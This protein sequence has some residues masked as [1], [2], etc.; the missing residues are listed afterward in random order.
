[1]KRPLPPASL[2]YFVLALLPQR[3]QETVTGDLLESYAERHRT[4]G[5]VSANLWYA[6]QAAS[7]VPRAAFTAYRSSAG[8]A[9]LCCFTATCGAWL[10]TM[11]LLLRHGNLLQQE[12]IA[13][14]I[15]AQ[16]LLTLVMLPLRRFRWLRW[17]AALGAVAIT[18][19]GSSALLAV[20]RGDNSFEGYIL[21]IALLLIVQAGMTWSELLHGRTSIG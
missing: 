11:S 17:A 15:L 6:R 12:S 18:W 20:G 3:D 19:L 9:F 14:L 1:M 7:F 21:L 2:Q 10:G 13:S 5:V 8:L 16:A 4:S